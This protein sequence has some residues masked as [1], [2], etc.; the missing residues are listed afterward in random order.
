MGSTLGFWSHLQVI[1][2]SLVHLLSTQEAL[3]PE[4]FFC[5]FVTVC[6]LC[7]SEGIIEQAF[8]LLKEALL[9]QIPGVQCKKFRCISICIL[10]GVA[11]KEAP[12][13]L[14]SYTSLSFTHAVCGT[15][16]CQD[17]A[18]SLRLQDLLEATTDR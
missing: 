12:Q 5:C 14:L 6:A 10:Q 8:Q 13:M 11:V 16:L 9:L 1:I 18:R 2:S 4:S 3:S 15:A 7:T 17:E